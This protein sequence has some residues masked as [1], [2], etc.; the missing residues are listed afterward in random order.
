LNDNE[1]RLHLLATDFSDNIVAGLLKIQQFEDEKASSKGIFNK[2]NVKDAQKMCADLNDSALKIQ[3]ELLALPQGIGSYKLLYF[4]FSD[5][6]KLLL[7][8][9]SEKIYM[10]DNLDSQTDGKFFSFKDYRKA[11]R[12]INKL[13]KKLSKKLFIFENDFHEVFD[14]LS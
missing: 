1:K 12:S 11:V 6:L 3:S 14:F 5:S 13:F 4:S 7:E 9:L 2:A 10:F 8:I